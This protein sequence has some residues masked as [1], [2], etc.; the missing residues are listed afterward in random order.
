M[1]SIARLFLLILVFMFHTVVNAQE[2]HH[3]YEFNVGSIYSKASSDD[4]HSSDGF[5]VTG[6][7]RMNSFNV[8]VSPMYLGEFNTK[9]LSDTYLDIYNLSVGLG[10]DAGLTRWLNVYGHMGINY[11]EVELY[12]FDDK[13]GQDDGV[14][15]WLGF[16]I[17]VDI[18]DLV[19]IYTGYRRYFDVSGSDIDMLTAQVGIEF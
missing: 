9:A 13:K 14:G 3:S 7:L 11:W 8:E 2:E 17:D 6:K 10:K 19:H 15:Y 1:V 16:G 5:M 4:Y 12:L 18:V